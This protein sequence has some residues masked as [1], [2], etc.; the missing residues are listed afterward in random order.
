MKHW[1]TLIA[2]AAWGHADMFIAA[3]LLAVVIW[4][5]RVYGMVTL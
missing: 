4:M 5:V 3:L 2:C 1:L